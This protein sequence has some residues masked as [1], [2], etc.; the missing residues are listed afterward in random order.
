[1]SKETKYTV[2][3]P[4]LYNNDILIKTQEY[5]DS[6]EDEVTEFHKTR[7]D[8]SDSFDRIIKVK[9]PTIEGLALHLNLN[10]DTMYDW[11][12]KHQEFSDL[13]DILLKKQADMLISKGLSGDYNPTIAKV[14]LTK[15]GYREGTELTGKDGKDLIPDKQSN[16]KAEEAINLFLGK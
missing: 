6:C 9:L 8:K 7:G 2:G 15:H 11:R 10:K 13:I 4:T 14:L 16:E 3:R 5:I 1:M 12:E